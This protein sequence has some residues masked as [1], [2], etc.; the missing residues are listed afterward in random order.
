MPSVRSIV[1]TALLT[2]TGAVVPWSS[3]EAALNA[4]LKL[5]GQKTGEIKGSV[6]QKGREH[7][8]KVLAVSH[9]IVSP[10]DP[11]SGLPTGKR[12]HKPI[13]LTIE[14]DRSAP[15]LHSAL[16]NNEAMSSFEIKFWAPAVSKG[17]GAE[18]QTYTIRLSNAHVSEVRTIKPADPSAPDVLEVSFT[19]QKIEW[20]WNDPSLV[21][22]D[23]WAATGGK[24]L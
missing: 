8:I 16:V 17:V 15:L 5:K 21:A 10:R 2:A 22:T 23:E 13:T 1:L 9:S 3:A 7:M 12:Q 4:Y 19:Y 20:A 24:G 11:A 6:T 18:V 14:L